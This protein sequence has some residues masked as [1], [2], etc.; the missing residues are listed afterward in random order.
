MAHARPSLQGRTC[1]RGAWSVE[2]YLPPFRFTG[3]YSRATGHS[4]LAALLVTTATR[5]HLASV[6]RSPPSAVRHPPFA[7]RHPASAIRH[8]SSAIRHLPS[9]ICHLLSAICHL[10]F[11]LPHSP[12]RIPHSA[13]F[14]GRVTHFPGPGK[15]GWP[16]RPPGEKL[17]LTVL[18]GQF[19]DA[20]F[21]CARSN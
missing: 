2:L 20:C 3:H 15:R 18:G 14:S 10:L 16:Q 17:V 11:L 5:S 8:L 21:C 13:F 19:R 4:C 12:L 7:I 9:A 1:R 6:I